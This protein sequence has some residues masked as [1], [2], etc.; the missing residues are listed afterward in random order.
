MFGIQVRGEGRAE[1][2][3]RKGCGGCRWEARDA[4][5]PEPYAEIVVEDTGR[6]IT[7]EEMGRLFEPFFTTKGTHGTGLGLAVTWGI[8]EGHGG[9][10][11]VESEP[12]RGTRFTVRL[13]YQVSEA[14]E[15]AIAATAVG[16]P[17]ARGI[18]TSG[19]TGTRA[20]TAA[21]GGGGRS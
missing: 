13:P 19:P 2:C 3:S 15:G 8:V 6:G 17:D 4:R 1:W 16:M 5:G 14:G 7:P 18:Q 21:A 12:G 9:S 10:I 11:A 20:A